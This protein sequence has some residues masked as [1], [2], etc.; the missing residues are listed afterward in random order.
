M[1]A[2]VAT[3]PAATDACQT[4]PYDPDAAAAQID[5]QWRLED[6]ADTQMDE[7][8]TAEDSEISGLLRAKTL[9]LGETEEDKDLKKNEEKDPE[10][11][12]HAEETPCSKEEKPMEVK[13]GEVKGKDNDGEVEEKK[14]MREPEK[15][16][17]SGSQPEVAKKPEPKVEKKPQPKDE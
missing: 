2:S 13:D 6:Y 1:Q 5:S 7:D 10:G 3:P 16:H 9:K 8:D 14:P 4:L 17:K 12:K 11:M 15:E